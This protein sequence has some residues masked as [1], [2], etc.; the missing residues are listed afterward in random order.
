MIMTFVYFLCRD[1]GRSVVFLPAC[2]NDQHPS[3]SP[4]TILSM[5][6]HACSVVPDSLPPCGLQATSP[7]SLGISRQEY[8]GGLPLPSFS[9]PQIE[10]LIYSSSIPTPYTLSHPYSPRCLK[11]WL[12]THVNEDRNLGVGLERFFII[13]PYPPFWSLNSISSSC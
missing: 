5:G 3:Y 12:L 8:W 6:V 10:F 4:F 9:L 11:E 13:P 7:L 2:L 1:A